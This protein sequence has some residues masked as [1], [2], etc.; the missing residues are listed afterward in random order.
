MRK[1]ERSE[2]LSYPLPGLPEDFRLQIQTDIKAIEDS[3]SNDAGVEYEPEDYGCFY[4]IESSAEAQR[5][6]DRFDKIVW[7][8][9]I[10]KNGLV[11]MLEIQG[12]SYGVQYYMATRHVTE[13]M[14]RGVLRQK[15][16][17]G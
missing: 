9:V 12:D 3:L 7:E 10:I 17:G 13:S 16:E 4:W 8:R 5:L 6:A 14:R 11:S 1:F 15:L 2:D